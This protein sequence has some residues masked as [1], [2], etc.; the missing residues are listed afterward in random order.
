MVL[1]LA[2]QTFSAS[3]GLEFKADE[4]ENIALN[5]GFSDQFE[6]KPQ[7]AFRLG[8]GAFIDLIVDGNF[9]FAEMSGLRHY[10]GFGVHF[11]IEDTANDNTAVN[12]GGHY[13]LRYDVNEIISIFGEIGVLVD[14]QDGFSLSSTRPG[15]GCTFYLPAFN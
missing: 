7:V 10:A 6:L 4:A 14:F 3:L 9:Y 11:K 5:I 13:G 1:L 2:V 15:L 12:L 8:D